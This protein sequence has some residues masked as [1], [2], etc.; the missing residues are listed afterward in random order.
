MFAIHF[1]EEHNKDQCIYFKRNLNQCTIA[2]FQLKLSYETRDSVFERN[3]ANII[4]NS[5]L[6]IY[7]D[8]IT[9]VSL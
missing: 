3:D 7:Y 1:V 8:I 9:P 4:S 6:N 5:F 2:D